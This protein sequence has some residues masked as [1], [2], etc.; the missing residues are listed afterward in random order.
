ML[1]SVVM[2]S[3]ILHSAPFAEQRPVAHIHWPPTHPPLDGND[4][5]ENDDGEDIADEDEHD[6]KDEDDDVEDEHDNGGL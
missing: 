6:D 4:L 3:P 5:D 1:H 2:A